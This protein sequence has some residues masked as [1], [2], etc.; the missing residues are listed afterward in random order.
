MCNVCKVDQDKVLYGYFPAKRWLCGLSQHC[1]SNFLVQC[2]LRRIRTT[3]NIQY[4][5]A[6]LSQL[7]RKLLNKSC[8]LTM[9]QHYTGKVL[10]QGWPLLIKTTL[11]IIFLCNFVLELW[12]NIAQVIFLCNIG[13]GTSR[14]YSIGYFL[15]KTC[16]RALGQHFTSNLQT[17]L[18]NIN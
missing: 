4:S 1:T 3:L 11:Q 12:V 8:L 9:G 17:Y 5:Y 6:M 16:L 13:T 18:D 7:D 15:A 14:Q 10:A 2:C